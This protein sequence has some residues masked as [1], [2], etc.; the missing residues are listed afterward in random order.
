MRA[1]TLIFQAA[2]ESVAKCRACNFAETQ[3][4]LA[5][6]LV[7]SDSIRALLNERCIPGII[8]S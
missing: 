6:K 1:E 5:E 7:G 4:S 8:S 3:S 2:T